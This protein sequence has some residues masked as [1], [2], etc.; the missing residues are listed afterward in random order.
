[1]K[2]MEMLFENILRKVNENNDH[3]FLHQYIG[4]AD[5]S[6]WARGQAWAVHGFTTSY[7]YTKYQPFLDK[8]VGAA[9]YFL[10]HL[11]SSTDLIPYWDFDAPHNSTAP[12]QPRDT[13]AAAIC[14]SAL[15]ELSQFVTVSEIRDRLLSSAKDIV[16]QLTTPKYLIIGNK[17]YLLRAIIANGTQGPYPNSHYDVATVYGEYYLTEAALR[18]Y[19]LGHFF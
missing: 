1:M 4:Y 16:N 14:A 10:S 3:T 5:W 18:L 12:Y 7:R 13:S 17:D 19:K 15:V 9:N 6:T 2:Q 8:A 11:P